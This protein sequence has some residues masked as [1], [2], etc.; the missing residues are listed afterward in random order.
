MRYQCGSGALPRKWAKTIREEL[1][2]QVIVGPC[3]PGREPQH[4]GW[5][6]AADVQRGDAQPAD[7]TI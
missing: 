3:N 2:R 1:E 6:G 7:L 4:P 5:V